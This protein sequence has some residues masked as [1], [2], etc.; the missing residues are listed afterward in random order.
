MNIILF[1]INTTIKEIDNKKKQK[2][3][4]KNIDISFFSIKFT[5]KITKKD[6]LEINKKS[7]K[8]DK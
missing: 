4:K 6:M 5:P 7:K 2:K 3:M 1:S 8:I